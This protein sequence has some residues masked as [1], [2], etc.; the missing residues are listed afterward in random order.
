MHPPVRWR[1]PRRTAS[2]PPPEN[3][4]GIAVSRVSVTG[5]A[6]AGDLAALHGGITAGP[7]GGPWVGELPRYVWSRRD[8]RVREFRL[9]DPG[10]GSYV[11]YELHP[12]EWPE[13]LA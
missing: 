3:S 2:S 7:T 10:K 9:E 11:V 12:S 1:A 8:E 5:P 6:A 13:G 4:P